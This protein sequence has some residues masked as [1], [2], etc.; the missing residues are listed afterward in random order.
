MIKNIIGKIR[1]IVTKG[2]VPV[3]SKRSNKWP[4][5]RKAHLAAHPTCALCGGDKKLEVHHIKPFHLHPELELDPSN[6]ITLCEST[7][8]GV[9]C[10][11]F[12]GH[13]GNFKQVNEDVPQNSQEYFD[14][15]TKARAA[16]KGAA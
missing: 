15:L 1:E 4:A 10:H 6:F 5:A 7:K 11:L 16:L 14:R 3:G 2:K 9:N 8:H 13:L 12:F